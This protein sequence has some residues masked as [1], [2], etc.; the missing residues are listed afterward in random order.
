MNGDHRADGQLEGKALLSAFADYA[1]TRSG[2]YEVDDN[3]KCPMAEFGL[4][5]H[6]DAYKARAGEFTI[7]VYNHAKDQIVSVEFADWHFFSNFVENART[8]EELT[9]RLGR[10][11]R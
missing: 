5:L 9:L 11:A 10:A 4:S 7:G 8:W 3:C 6:P 1:A 2:P